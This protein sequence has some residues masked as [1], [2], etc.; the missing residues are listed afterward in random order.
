MPQSKA[1]RSSVADVFGLCPPESIL[2]SGQKG[3]L[4]LS[5]S[6][7]ARCDHVV[8]LWPAEFEWEG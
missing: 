6:L 7:K 3:G 4:Y 1:I 8:K 5:P 2:F